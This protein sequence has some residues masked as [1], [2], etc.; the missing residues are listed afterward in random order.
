MVDAPWRAPPVTSAMN[1]R[2]MPL[3]STPGSVQK[4]LSSTETTASGTI[5]PSCGEVSMTSLLG[6][7]KMP[8]LRQWSSYR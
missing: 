3:M 6:G 4:R 5:G 1:A 7:A 2:A 8:I